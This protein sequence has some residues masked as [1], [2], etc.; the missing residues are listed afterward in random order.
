MLYVCATCSNQCMC[1]HTS[2][3]YIDI[4]GRFSRLNLLIIALHEE[5]RN[6][7]ALLNILISNQLRIT[8]V[9]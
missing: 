4:I 1:K 3:K 6:N 8:Q 2:L 9:S 7:H 5:V